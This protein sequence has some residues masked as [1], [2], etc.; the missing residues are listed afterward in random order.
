MTGSFLIP[1]GI[2][3][4]ACGLDILILLVRMYSTKTLTCM[5]MSSPDAV[6]VNPCMYRCS[7]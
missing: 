5:Q 4:G 2:L 3:R 1:K 7:M 6:M